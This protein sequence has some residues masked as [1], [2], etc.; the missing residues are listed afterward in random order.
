MPT[1]RSGGSVPGLSKSNTRP[2][3]V[4]SKRVPLLQQVEERAC[5]VGSRF[6]HEPVANAAL[7]VELEERRELAGL[8][9]T[10][11]PVRRGPV[12]VE[13][14]LQDPLALIELLGDALLQLVV[15]AQAEVL[16][17][18]LHL[19]EVAGDRSSATSRSKRARSVLRNVTSSPISSA[20]LFAQCGRGR[21]ARRAARRSGSAVHP[22]S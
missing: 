10:I 4:K 6:H 3:R 14:L 16:R 8:Q 1:S 20:C 11:R 12:R 5:L 13:V 18:A 17:I 7:E 2:L 22:G 15:A 21:G 9:E 19:D